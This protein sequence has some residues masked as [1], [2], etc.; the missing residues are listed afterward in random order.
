MAPHPPPLNEQ[1][2]LAEEM[3]HV[4]SLRGGKA[5]FIGLALSGGGIRSA[6]FNLGILQSLA[7]HDMLRQFD[8]LSTVSG[9]GY[10]GS[11][12]SALI[13]RSPNGLA[14]AQEVLHPA[15]RNNAEAPQ[16]RFLRRYSS[17]LTPRVGLSGDTLAALATYLRNFGL[18]LIPLVALGAALIL[19][20]YLLAHAVVLEPDH[21]GFSP[22]WLTPLLLVLGVVF[23]AAGLASTTTPLHGLPAA[24]PEWAWAILAPVGVAGILIA[25]AM[26]RGDLSGF[27]TA[28][29]IGS[30]TLAYGFAWAL[31]YRV[32]KWLGRRQEIGF[33]RASDKWLL[34]PMTLL[35][36]ALA[37]WL[38]S[39]VEALLAPNPESP[40]FDLAAAWRGMALGAPLV[41][42]SFAIAVALHIGLLRRI[43]SHQAREW[44][45]RMGG[46]LLAATIAWS[47]AFASVGLA[48]AAAVWAHGWSVQAGGAWAAIT[49]A[50]VWLAKSPLTGSSEKRPWLDIAVRTTPWIFLFGFALLLSASV[51]FVLAGE[52][53]PNCLAVQP[54][55]IRTLVTTCPSCTQDKVM[56]R[57]FS[58][59]S[60]D[61]FANIDRL[62]PA[63]LLIA[64]LACIG[65]FLLAGWRIDINLFSL[66]HFYRN[67]LVRA[68]LGASNYPDRVSHPFT[69]FCADDDIQLAKLNSQR[70]FHI[71]NT[72]LNLSGGDE[73]A[74]QTR[75]AA[76]FTFTPLHCGFEYRATRGARKDDTDS[77]PLGGYRP[78]G[79]YQSRWGAYLGSAMSISG[80]AASP[81]SGY[82]TSAALAALMTV[83]NVRLGQWLGNPAHPQAWTT[84]APGFGARY[85]LKELTASANARAKFLYLS[86][87]GHF[88]NLGIYELARRRCR[89]IVAVDAGCDPDYAFDDLANAIRK[90]NIDLGAEIFINVDAIRPVNQFKHAVAHHALGIIHYADGGEGVLLYIKASLTGGE[91]PDILNYAANHQA[92]PHDTTADQSFDEDQFESYRRLGQHVGDE[93][94]GAIRAAAESVHGA[95]DA[96]AFFAQAATMAT[97]PGQ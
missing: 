55:E 49:A 68:Y 45:S 46:L 71:I 91:A 42:L 60:A 92:F 8:Y 12:L 54:T 18:N 14:G 82:H 28:T 4:R 20:M 64:L 96:D 34:I 33:S 83:F 40:T 93:L 13:H 94:F 26:L 27:D 31:G 19:A 63:T 3:E 44:W 72:A 89:L 32:W 88:E 90:C 53:C 76:S 41:M 10:I 87:G 51:F 95:F 37:G 17:Y 66:H 73:L 75:R 22:L 50:G 16:L 30:C 23:C 5:E 24:Q 80:A 39:G 56:G 81:L 78:T 77:P 29:W 86:D 69:G 48:P 67:R 58:D 97:A 38:L 70:P 79:Q 1:A 2:M 7:R 43:L 65:A 47:L 62:D 57:N 74:W 84:S 25:L 52:F 15:Q 35:A 85:L 61:V 21:F 9:G 59:I 11:W 36:G 6:T